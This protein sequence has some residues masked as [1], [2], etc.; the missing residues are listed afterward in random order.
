[1]ARILEPKSVTRE[2]RTFRVERETPVNGEYRLR[3]HREIIT[4]ADGE[5]IGRTE[6]LFAYDELATKAS[7]RPAFAAYLVAIKTA[8]TGA[9]IVAAEAKP[10]DDLVAEVDDDRAQEQRER[11][12]AAKDAEAQP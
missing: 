4:R 11:E 1:M 5:V 3:I 6:R 12:A 10:Y 7:T 9:D 2:E 8:K